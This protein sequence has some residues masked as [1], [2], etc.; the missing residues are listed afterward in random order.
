MVRCVS[1][2]GY[3]KDMCFR[4]IGLTMCSKCDNHSSKLTVDMN[5]EGVLIV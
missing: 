1:K 3:Q 2:N 5:S 4:K